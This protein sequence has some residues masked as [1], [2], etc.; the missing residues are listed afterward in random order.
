MKENANAYCGAGMTVYDRAGRALIVEFLENVDA[1]KIM[2]TLR[3]FMCHFTGMAYEFEMTIALNEIDSGYGTVF[4][5]DV[6][7]VYGPMMLRTEI[8]CARM[9]SCMCAKSVGVKLTKVYYNVVVRRE[10]KAAKEIKEGSWSEMKSREEN[11]GPPLRG[12]IDCVRIVDR[13]SFLSES[14]DLLSLKLISTADDFHQRE[15][16]WNLEIE[17]NERNRETVYCSETLWL[18]SE[19]SC[20]SRN[21]EGRH[22]GGDDSRC[23]QKL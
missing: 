7:H 3:S 16:E 23:T 11:S 8:G 2:I 13:V 1:A 18:D 9:G 20:G 21:L 22:G 15:S 6:R 19:S 17:N 14:A 12:E 10:M 4:R 5:T